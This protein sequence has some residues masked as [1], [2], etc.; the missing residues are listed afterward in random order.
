[1]V[2]ALW[3]CMHGLASLSLSGR[4]AVLGQDVDAL[5]EKVIAFAIR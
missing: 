2:I 3:T 5:A 4:L 1:V